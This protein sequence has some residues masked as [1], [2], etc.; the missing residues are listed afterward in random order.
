[1]H[2]ESCFLKG[3]RKMFPHHYYGR[4]NSISRYTQPVCYFPP[5]PRQIHY[6]AG[7]RQ[8]P[9]VN[10]ATFMSSAKHMQV[11]MRDASTLLDRMAN[12]QQFSNDLMSAAQQ[13]Q[14]KKAEE[15]IKATGIKSQPRV[16][17][18]PDGL[19]LVFEAKDEQGH[20]CNLTLKLRWM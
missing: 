4:R 2:P 10:P 8:F 6:T 1:V 17:Y 12:V 15:M 11:L 5:S 20:C 19:T 16:S 13:S 18:T 3:A 9:S 7:M 14:T